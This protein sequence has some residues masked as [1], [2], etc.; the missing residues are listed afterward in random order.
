MSAADKIELLVD[1]RELLVAQEYDVQLNFFKTPNTFSLTVASNKTTLD[2]MRL[3]RP[4]MK[5]SL[6]VNGVTVFCGFIDGYESLG[7]GGTTLT[8][9]GRDAMSQLVRA[10]VEAERSFSHATY[11]DLAEAAV[12]ASGIAEA[13]IFSDV[14]SQRAAVTGT[15]IVET[16]H[17]QSLKLRDAAGKQG[18][19]LEVKAVTADGSAY[20]VVAVRQGRTEVST[21]VNQTINRVTG[22]KTERPI[23]WD[24]GETYFAA[25]KKEGDRA[26][27]FLRAGVDPTGKDPFVFLLS[28]P[29][30]NQ[31]AKFNLL[32]TRDPDRDAANVVLCERQGGRYVMTGRHSKYVVLGQ[33][34]GGKDGRKQVR[35]EFVDEEA[36]AGLPMPASFVRKDNQ[37]KSTRQANFMA[38]KACAEARRANRTFPYRIKGSHSLPL[39]ENPRE[40]GLPMPDVVVYLRD[41]EIGVDGDM[42]VE[43]VRFHKSVG[44]GTYTDLMLLDPTDL[45]FGEDELDRALSPKTTTKRGWKHR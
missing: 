39:A 38:R 12:K 44:D 23:K 31:R 24:A 4:G 40:R 6:R 37:A 19:T 28:A 21:V 16:T 1:G 26:G 35:G 22:Y 29:D 9:S 34:G 3:V 41:D 25:F 5:F 14:A 42:W 45:V 36:L 15:P 11:L 7:S 30:P 13:T 33:A 8:I 27:V 20:D 43:S 10:H 32:N 17:K 18:S 2:L